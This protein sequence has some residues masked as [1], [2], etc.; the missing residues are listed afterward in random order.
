MSE[1]DFSASDEDSADDASS[2]DESTTDISDCDDVREIEWKER[3]PRIRRTIRDKPSTKPGLTTRSENVNSF[4]ECFSSQ[5]T[6]S[7]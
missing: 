2:D 3:M 5:L 1:S 7:E 6:N 4:Y